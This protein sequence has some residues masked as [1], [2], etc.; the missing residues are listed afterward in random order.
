MR[1]SYPV[2]F[3]QNAGS[4]LGISKVGVRKAGAK[5]QGAPLE[6]TDFLCHVLS[7][8]LLKILSLSTVLVLLLLCV[9]I[10]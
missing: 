8:I 4:S 7:I 2:Q 3:Q 5:T 1:E 6:A 9:V 10:S